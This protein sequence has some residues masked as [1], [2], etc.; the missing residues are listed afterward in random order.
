M[1]NL[2]LI[3]VII[4]LIICIFYILMLNITLSK[5]NNRISKTIITH[6]QQKAESDAWRKDIKDIIS[7]INNNNLWEKITIWELKT[8][9]KKQIATMS[10]KTHTLRLKWKRKN[11]QK[12]LKHLFQNIYYLW[13]LKII[14]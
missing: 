14:K 1:Q 7:N 10:I 9:F 6:K 11:H 4:N 5:I 8:L 3:I 2:I 13:K 12:K